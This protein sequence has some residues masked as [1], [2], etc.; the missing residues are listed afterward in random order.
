MLLRRAVAGH[1][2]GVLC[3]LISPVAMGDEQLDAGGIEGHP[4][5][6]AVLGR[7]QHRACRSFDERPRE[8]DGGVANVDVSPSKGEELAAARSGQGGQVQ[9]GEELDVV[10]SD[11]VE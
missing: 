11:H 4:I 9:V 6:A 8:P 1:T 2:G 7:P 5:G 3:S 10:A